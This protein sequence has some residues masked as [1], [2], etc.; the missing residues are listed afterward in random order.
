VHRG[1]DI[2][3]HENESGDEAEIIQEDKGISQRSA[4]VFPLR[5]AQM[6]ITETPEDIPSTDEEPPD[7]GD[8]EDPETLLKDRPI[9]ERLLD[10]IMQ[11][12][13]PTKV[14]MIAEQA[15]CDTET[16]REYLAWFTSMGIVREHAGRPIRYERNES[17]LFWRRVEQIREAYSEEE[18]VSE[19]TDTVEAISEYRK[20]FDAEDPGEV[21][22]REASREDT[23]E[24]TW[25]A[26]SAW[27]TLERRAELLDHA[28]QDENTHSGSV[29]SIN[30]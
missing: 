5:R 25:E 16:A 14:A 21:S 8:W 12:R 18:I 29:G 24:E 30:A 15:D 4:Y 26:L 20:Q 9:R 2:D 7:F 23:I 10:V 27:K 6:D 1:F 3:G 13:E 11:T 22:L 19:L 28:R 17:Y